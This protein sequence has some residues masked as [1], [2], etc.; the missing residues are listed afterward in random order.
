MST[1]RCHCGWPAEG[2]ARICG[3]TDVWQRAVHRILVGDVYFSAGLYCNFEC[4]VQYIVL[5][6]LS[7]LLDSQFGLTSLKHN[8]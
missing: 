3:C 4:I 1:R 6:R 5:G 8:R 7:Q 2:T